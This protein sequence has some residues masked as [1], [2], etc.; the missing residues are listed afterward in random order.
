M[1]DALLECFFGAGKVQGGDQAVY[2][3]HHAG[4]SHPGFLTLGDVGIH[5]LIV[6]DPF[7]LYTLVIGKPVGVVCQVF[8]VILQLFYQRSEGV[9]IYIP[10]CIIYA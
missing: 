1:R 3:C 10:R 2:L 7:K 4:W 5:Y 9:Y 8:G 6:Q